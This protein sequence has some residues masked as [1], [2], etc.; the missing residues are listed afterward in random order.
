APVR[1]GRDGAE[2]MSIDVARRLVQARAVEVAPGVLAIELKHF[3]SYD[4]SS[5]VLVDVDHARVLRT[6]RGL[7]PAASRGDARDHSAGVTPA[8]LFLDDSGALVRLDLAT[9]ARQ[10]VLGGR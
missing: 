3:E 4:E 10:K 2:A 8:S 7:R 6:Q 5:S 9:G 1:R